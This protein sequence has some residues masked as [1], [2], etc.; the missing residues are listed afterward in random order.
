MKVNIESLL[1]Q[2]DRWNPIKPSSWSLRVFYQYQTEMKR[3]T[4]AYMASNKYIYRILGANGALWS[5][6]VSNY[7]DTGVHDSLIL[8]QWSNAFNEFDNWTRL[9]ELMALN[10]YLEVYISSVVSAAIESDPG[11]L[12]KSPHSIDGI[13]QMKYGVKIKKEFLENIITGCTKGDWQSRISNLSSLFGGLPV[14]LTSGISDLEKIR[15]IRNKVGHAFGRDIE[16]SRDY[17]ITNITRMERLSARSFLRYMYLV[18]NIVHDIDNMVM[19]NHI[20][21]FQPLLHYH[22]IRVS[23]P[24]SYNNG[25]RMM[26]LKKSIGK[27]TQETYSKAFCRWVVEYYERL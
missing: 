5:D 20:G 9:N 13:K 6:M 10:S 19:A 22:R 16:K 17:A 3:M 27:D 4:T 8:H 1:Q 21:N 14:S 2:F 24:D 26:I 11:L 25:E 18:Q 15:I 7:M 23:I 12:V